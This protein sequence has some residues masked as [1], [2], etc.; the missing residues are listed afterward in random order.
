MGLTTKTGVKINVPT[1]MV[2]TISVLCGLVLISS[3]GM[4]AATGATNLANRRYVVRVMNNTDIVMPESVRPGET[5]VTLLGLNFIKRGNNKKDFSLIFKS[6]QFV[7]RTPDEIDLSFVV[8]TLRDSENNIMAKAVPTGSGKKY[9]LVFC[10][11]TNNNQQPNNRVDKY[12]LTASFPDNLDTG[13]FRI[14]MQPTSHVNVN[15]VINNQEPQPAII[16]GNY[17]N[18][19]RTVIEQTSARIENSTHAPAS[20]IVAGT[21][22]ATLGGF[23]INVT[24]N[25][26]VINEL[27]IRIV[28]NRI[29]ADNLVITNS[30]GVSLTLP[31]DWSDNVVFDNWFPALP[32]NTTYFIK[33]DV[34]TNITSEE[35][36]QIVI[37]SANI[38]A[39]EPITNQ[40]ILFDPGIDVRLSTQTIVNGGSLTVNLDATT[41][42][43][44]LVLAE[45][46]HNLTRIK[47]NASYEDI[48]VR[49][50]NLCVQDG[51][52][53]DSI[54]GDSD[55]IQYI[56]VTTNSGQ[57]VGG[58]PMNSGCQNYSLLPGEL[59]IP[60]GSSVGTVLTI[61]AMM[62]GVGL[63]EVGTSGADVKVG[64]A[65]ANGI[66]AVGT[67]SGLV[68]PINY[69]NGMGS[70]VIL[71]RSA[72][73]MEI[74]L[75]ENFAATLT[76]GDNTLYMFK[77]FGESGTASG[78]YKISFWVHADNVHLENFKLIRVENGEVLGEVSYDNNG[79]ITFNPSILTS[80]NG[81]ELILT[82]TASGITPDSYSYVE[83][84]L[85]NDINID[86]PAP[87]TFNQIDS[88]SNFIWTDF[89]KSPIDGPFD[90]ER[91]DKDQWFNSYL[92][93]G[94]W[95]SVPSVFIYSR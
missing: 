37:D 14:V 22:N 36:M 62:S 41:P 13:R 76:N 77:V 75:R 19:G 81:M 43:S 56:G 17:I 48:E 7:I 74:E 67:Q 33:G 20:T 91:F 3:F 29:L 82:A 28:A 89:S 10:D 30:E 42:E 80:S 25:N 64:I 50:L 53:N 95:P 8:F 63:N 31:K 71:V 86:Q 87:A 61:N 12:Y 58:G 92:I 34:R 46:Q 40:P 32:G 83:T 55:E 38:K 16:K 78:V 26:I 45:N 1:A 65:D 90:A 11:F 24:G 88:S 21:Q 18:F 70:P 4:M 44:R 85:L 79:V 73:I 5:D 94:L 68:I 51:G 84:K 39:Y 23:D 27:P 66:V 59:V 57:T 15:V 60:A 35:I 49:E 52:L 54:I 47:L 69:A 6:L 2:A 93:N 72:P 9:H